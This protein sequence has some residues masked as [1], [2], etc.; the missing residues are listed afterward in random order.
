MITI[1]IEQNQKTNAGTSFYSIG[2]RYAPV[3]DVTPLKRHLPPLLHLLLGLGNDLCS[4]F[5]DWIAQR[6]E[7]IREEEKE[8]QNRSLIAE[9]KHDESLVKFVDVKKELIVLKNKRID[10]NRKLKT[11]KESSECKKALNEEKV[12]S[13]Q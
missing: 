3:L 6:I 7:L 11:R 12:L 8:A 10:I 9:I 1:A 2:V 5:K 4:K 13:L